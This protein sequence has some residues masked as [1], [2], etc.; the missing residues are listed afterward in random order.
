MPARPASTASV[1]AAANEVEAAIS[2]SAGKAGH[3]WNR[4]CT[5]AVVGN[6]QAAMEV[7][8]T[9]V[10][11]RYGGLDI[12]HDLPGDGTV[13]TTV[14]GGKQRSTSS[15]GRQ[16]AGSLRAS[17]PPPNAA[18]LPNHT[19]ADSRGRGREGPAEFTAPSQDGADG[20]GPT[21]AATNAGEASRRQRLD[22]LEA[23]VSRLRLKRQR[24]K[25]NAK[26]RLAAKREQ[27][28]D[29][30]EQ[31]GDTGT[32][33]TKVN[34]PLWSSAPDLKMAFIKVASE[35]TARCA[36]KARKEG[37]STREVHLQFGGTRYSATVVSG[38]VAV[39]MTTA[40]RSV[41]LLV[42]LSDGLTAE[43]LETLIRRWS[44]RVT[45]QREERSMDDDDDD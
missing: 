18:D 33:M 6:L 19:D 4:H 3:G 35:V 41:D 31:Y 14:E 10:H 16:P 29:F 43:R 42:V 25:A 40:E 36:A 17:R 45:Q 26:S 2:R 30:V 32:P 27:V 7:G 5:A 21:D 24:Y 39:E 22:E 44:K 12:R 34:C 1:A 9:H 11:F 28:A 8:S 38:T 20:A 15:E 37:L 13:R 23:Q